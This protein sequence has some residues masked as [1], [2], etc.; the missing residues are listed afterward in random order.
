MEEDRERKPQFGD[1]DFWPSV[2]NPIAPIREQ[3]RFQTTDK[4]YPRQRPDL[5]ARRPFLNTLR[6]GSVVR[7]KDGRTYHVREIEGIQTGEGTVILIDSE[8]GKT[9]P[10]ISTNYI[11]PG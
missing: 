9:S 2:K 7:G 11:M 8:T 4:L 5:L 3:G 10:K 6:E 1:R